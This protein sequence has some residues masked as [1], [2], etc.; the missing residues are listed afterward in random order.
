[1]NFQNRNTTVRM[2][3]PA[4]MATH[5]VAFSE[6]ASFLYLADIM[7]RFWALLSSSAYLYT[8]KTTFSIFMGK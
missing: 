2:D 4:P 3:T 8:Y 7:D 1:M 5:E 6:V